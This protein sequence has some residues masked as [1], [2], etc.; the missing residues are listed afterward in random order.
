MPTGPLPGPA[1][2]IHLI[3]INTL[4]LLAQNLHPLHQIAESTNQE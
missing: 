1:E 4:F 3:V 2:I